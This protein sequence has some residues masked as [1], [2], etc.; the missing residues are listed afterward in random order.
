MVHIKWRGPVAAALLAVAGSAGAAEGEA[1]TAPPEP[2]SPAAPAVSPE[3]QRLLEESLGADAPAPAAAPAAPGP[4]SPLGGLDLSLI[5]DASAAYFSVDEP[6]QLGAH[7]PA[8]TGFDF[9]GLELS[10]GASADPFFRFDGNLVFLPTGV[11][12]EEA[13][14]T[15]LALPANLQV[16]AGQFLTRFGRIN[17]THPHTWQFVDQPLALGKF[18]GG[19]GSRG[20]GLEG[21]W[22]APLPWFV[23]LSAAANGPSAAHDHDGE[24]EAEAAHGVED[25]GDLRYTTALKQFFPLGRDWGLLWGLSAQLGPDPLGEGTRASIYGT[26]LR[27]RYRPVASPERAAVTL[28]V[29][30]LHRDRRVGGVSL[31][32]RGGYAQL[33]WSIDPAWETGV[34]YELVSGVED[35]PAA[36]GWTG[37]RRRASAQLTLFPSHFSRIRLQA[38]RDEPTYRREEIWAAFLNLEVAVGAHGA[39]AY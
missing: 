31:R 38:S 10:I 26:D 19:E 6:Q 5:L 18:F 27:L 35:D 17:A 39:H 25:L 13:Y 14:A 32:D 8:L 33:V 7:D 3:E 30:G 29:E 2:R 12:I 37:L 9:G 28:Q 23:E 16:R 1:G 21:S 4:S 11:E 34:R 24:E 36:P 15:T 20:V 22:L